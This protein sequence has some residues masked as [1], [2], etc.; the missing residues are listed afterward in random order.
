MTLCTCGLVNC[1]VF[2]KKIECVYDG[3]DDSRVVGNN[4]DCVNDSIAEGKYDR[5]NLCLHVMHVHVIV[6]DCRR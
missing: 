2:G 4:V 3:P 1:S 6:F 5:L